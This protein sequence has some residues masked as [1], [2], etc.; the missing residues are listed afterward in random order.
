MGTLAENEELNDINTKITAISIIEGASRECAVP[1]GS[2][3]Q[4]YV[5]SRIREIAGAQE[6]DEELEGVRTFPNP[7][8]SSGFNEWVME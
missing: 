3:L 2:D 6:R 4:H 8:Y 7:K 1:H 5:G